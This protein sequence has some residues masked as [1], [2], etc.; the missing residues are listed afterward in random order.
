MSETILLLFL[1][2]DTSKKETPS[3]KL[4][5]ERGRERER[6]RGRERERDGKG[7]NVILARGG[8]E[9]EIRRERVRDLKRLMKIHI[10]FN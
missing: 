6:E 2:S 5:L 3:A 4:D 9:Q 10:Q 7:S 8:R 1:I